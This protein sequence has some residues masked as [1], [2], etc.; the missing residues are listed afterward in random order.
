M[1]RNIIAAGIATALFSQAVL[2]DGDKIAQLEQQVIQLSELVASQSETDKIR[3]NGF[4][5]VSYAGADNDAG[6]AGVEK[7]G[8]FKSDS[9]FGLQG[10]FQASDNLEATIQ[11]V[12]RGEENWDPD[13]TWAFLGYTFDNDVT[14]RG[15]L[16][17]LPL[18]MLSEYLEVGYA[19]PWARS[20]EEVYGRVPITSFTGVDANYEFELEDSYL[21]V[22]LFTGSEEMTGQ[23][24]LGGSGS[25]EDIWG[26][27]ATWS[28]DYWTVRGS[29]TIAKV[30]DVTFPATSPLQD[31]DS[32]S[33]SYSSFGV[34]YEDGDWLL[35]GEA[36]RTIV[37]GYFADTQAGYITAG[38]N[39]ASVMPYIS[40][41]RVETIDDEDRNVIETLA[42][43]YQ[44]TSYSLGA[45]WDIQPGLALKGDVT[46]ANKFDGSNGGLSTNSYIPAQGK[47]SYDD[48][49]IYTVKLDATF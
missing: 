3:V 37:D 8:D 4:G 30:E 31:I 24:E 47:F 9:L 40:L 36:T 25:V 45:R 41:A 6:F 12:A 48:S 32:E 16:L 23:S 28:D 14:V 43:S 20:P 18:F 2:A 44:R 33:G 1:K 27:V 26:A 17:R 38:Y 7:S 15:G 35:M 11:V 22:Q 29:Y 34:R 49:L 13:V 19:Q 21:G 39:I 5:S 42:L 46:Y 10:T